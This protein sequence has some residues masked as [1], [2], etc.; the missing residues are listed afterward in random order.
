[1][2]IVKKREL[3]IWNLKKVNIFSNLSAEDFE[4]LCDLLHEDTFDMN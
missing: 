1:M 3:Y 4:K 2:S